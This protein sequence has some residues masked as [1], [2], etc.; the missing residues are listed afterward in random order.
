MVSLVYASGWQEDAVP[1]PASVR[2]GDLA[3]LAWSEFNFSFETPSGFSLAVSS[4]GRRVS[5]YVINP[6]LHRVRLYTR[7]LDGGE[8]GEIAVRRY[9]AAQLLIFRGARGVG[10]TRRGDGRVP[11]SPGGGAVVGILR[12]SAGQSLPSGVT[13]EDGINR[14]AYSSTEGFAAVG[15]VDSPNGGTVGTAQGSV[16]LELLPQRTPFAPELL[17]PDPGSQV[18]NQG[19]VSFGWQHKPSVAGGFQDA[20]QLR[21]DIDG[22]PRYWNA[23]TN[24]FQSSEVTNSTRD[25]TVEIPGAAFSPVG[26]WWEVRTREGRDGLWSPWSDGRDFVA[27]SPPGV[28]V[29]SPSG[30]VTDD[31]RPVVTGTATTPQGELTGLRVQVFTG[32]GRELH[33]SGWQPASGNSFE[34]QLPVLDWDNGAAYQVVVQVSQT[35]GSRSGLGTSDFEI[36]WT[37]P[38]EP[39]ITATPAKQGVDVSVT[40]PAGDLIEVERIRRDGTW[41]PVTTVEVDP[42]V[43]AWTGDPDDSTSTRTTVEGTVT[44]LFENPRFVT[45]APNGDLAGFSTSFNAPTLQPDQGGGNEL[46]LTGTNDLGPGHG[47][48][49]PL[50]VVGVAALSGTGL[51][52]VKARV[53]IPEGY[54]ASEDEDVDDY[55]NEKIA[56]RALRITKDG[57]FLDN[58]FVQAP[59]EPGEYELSVSA[60]VTSTGFAGFTLGGSGKPGQEITWLP[61]VTVVEGAYDGPRFTGASVDG[62][63]FTD[64]AAPFG[65]STAWRARAVT[66]LDGMRLTSEWVNSTPVINTDKS[67]YLYSALD[68][69]RTWQRIKIVDDSE[70]ELQRPTA[71]AYGLGDTR[72]RV[73]YGQHRGRAGTLTLSTL[74]DPLSELA[75]LTALLEAGETLV[76]RWGAEGFHDQ[77][78]D[79]GTL[80]FSVAESLTES[81]G[82]QTAVLKGRRLTVPWVEQ[83]PPTLGESNAPITHD[84]RFDEGA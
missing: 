10:A 37:A 12:T 38:A 21:A 65:V 29:T 50:G 16:V 1:W 13:W 28:T 61:G 47:W 17:E 81:R 64:V 40:A 70:H 57:N 33:D 9:Y 76:L 18:S 43:Y 19:Q 20:Y 77:E 56:A 25:E 42:A 36:S 58:E 54:D 72:P 7:M 51:V 41:E 53:R 27:V 22:D 35:G 55:D 52:T 68:P 84:I 69:I 74:T 34:Y 8:S 60:N 63:V 73:T 32:T 39:S 83:A 6:R 45:L 67:Q 80:V 62:F 30:A 23:T 15:W 24:S 46:T 66:T 79:A 26:N 44:N 71:V 48:R 3:V 14:I 31:L 4:G 5:D 78:E 2:A 59:S 49:L 82:A 11:T 75:D